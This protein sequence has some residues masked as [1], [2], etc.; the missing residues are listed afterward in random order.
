[1]GLPLPRSRTGFWQENGV[2]KP[3]PA[4]ESRV[5]PKRNMG[6]GDAQATMKFCSLIQMTPPGVAVLDLEEMK[7]PEEGRKLNLSPSPT[8]NTLTHD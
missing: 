6:L 2:W 3:P 7:Q 4:A 1:M 8:I 5:T